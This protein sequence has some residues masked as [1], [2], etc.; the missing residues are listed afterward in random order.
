MYKY[1]VKMPSPKSD[2]LEFESGLHITML[3][4]K[5]LAEDVSIVFFKDADVVLNLALI[6]EVEINGVKYQIRS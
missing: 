1:K 4:P 2:D 5:V 6:S 3:N